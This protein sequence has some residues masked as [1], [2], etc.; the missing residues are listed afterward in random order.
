MR[1]NNQV[2]RREFIAS[3]SVLLAASQLG[4]AEVADNDADK[5]ALNGGAKTVTRSAPKAARWGEPELQQL[6]AAVK[7]DSLYYWNNQQTKL[8][9][10]RYRAIY[11]H[12]YVQ[13]CSSGSASLHIAVA[14]A[15]IAPGDEVITSGITI[16]G[17]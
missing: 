7:Q 9:M 2:S 4:V 10:E 12:K 5:L 6:A 13:P 11:G 14:A 16:S 15:G 1:P 17:L 3:T 8:L